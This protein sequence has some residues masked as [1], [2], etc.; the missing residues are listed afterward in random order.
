[1]KTFSRQAA[2]R[3]T[4]NIYRLFMKI[5]STKCYLN[6]GL[7]YICSSSFN[8]TPENDEMRARDS[9]NQIVTAIEL[10]RLFSF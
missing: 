10:N 2:A 4:D 1:M 8:E 6:V 7:L 5:T 9:N 3:E